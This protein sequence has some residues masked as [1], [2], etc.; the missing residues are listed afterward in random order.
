M[1]RQVLPEN[2]DNQTGKLREQA[3]IPYGFFFFN[4]F[5][6][7]NLDYSYE[8]FIS[9]TNT[10]IIKECKVIQELVTRY[11]KGQYTVSEDYSS[12]QVCIIHFEEGE[13]IH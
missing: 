11:C 7:F 2:D 6:A 9:F 8:E 12:N 13:G 5:K 4:F 1:D 3:K 10:P